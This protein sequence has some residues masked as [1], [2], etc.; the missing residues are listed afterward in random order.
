MRV[1]RVPLELVSPNAIGAASLAGVVISAI[2]T[3]VGMFAL[4]DLTKGYFEQ[5]D[6]YRALFYMLI[7][8]T[9]FFFAM[10]YTEGLFIGLAFSCLALSKRKQW[11]WAAILAMLAAWTRAHGA[12]LA[13]PLAV[14]WLT[15]GIKD[16]NI[17]ESLRDWKWWLQGVSV[18]LPVGAYLLWRTSP[19]GEGWAELQTFYFGR[20]L[21]TW[22]KSL[23]DWKRAYEYARYMGS[24]GF[25]YFLIEIG[26]ILLALVGSV[27][28]LKKDLP[29]AL[30]SL[31]VILLSVFSGSAQSMARYML[32]VPAMFI[33]LAQLGKNKA[34]DRVWSIVSLL[35]LGMET[36]LYTFDMW[37]G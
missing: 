22:D 17:K 37:V 35:L 12:A 3:L 8:P 1:L 25:V 11:F 36:M 19:L 6:R 20:G 13:L 2:G 26:A 5:D 30:F 4:W 31:A 29:V 16:R 21:A 7:F 14:T 18:L 28:L 9:G 33:F 32:I 34:F 27:W 24:E 10:V 15:D 23:A